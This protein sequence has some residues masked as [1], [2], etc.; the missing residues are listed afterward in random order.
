M[1]FQWLQMRISEEKDRR[2]REAAALDRLPKALEEVH[3]AL[4]ACIE[5]YQGAFG[6]EAAELHHQ[7]AKMRI[8]SREELEGRWQQ[9]ARVEVA[10]VPTLPGIQ[11]DNGNG[12][13]PLLIEIGLLPGDKLFFRDRAQD[14]YVTME[15][16]TRRILDRAFFPKLGE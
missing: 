2:K 12:G 11:I 4:V 8:I 16:L 1:S 13:D 10:M 5:T 6:P 9:V 7:P 3:R 14:Q 15:E